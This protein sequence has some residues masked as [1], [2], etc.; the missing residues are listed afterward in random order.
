M[1]SAVDDDWLLALPKVELHVHLEG[2]MSVDTVRLLTDRHG[3]DPTPVWSDGF[4]ERFSFVDFPDFAAQYFY[5]LSLIRTGEDLATVTDDLAVAMAAQNIRYAEV[6]TTAY[7][8]FLDR[9]DRPGMAREEYR[10]GLTEGRRRAAARGVEL[11]WVIDI[12]RDIEV[13]DEEVTI[14]YVTSDL[15]PE[16]LVALGLGGY[17]VGFPAAPYAEQFERARAIGLPAVPHAGETEGAESVRSAI[18]DLGAVRIGHGVRCL[19]DPALVERIAAN[20]VML[21][22]CPTSNLLLGVVDD[23][24]DHALPALIES[25]V[26]VCVNTDDPGWFATDLMTELRLASDRLGVDAAR[27]VAM[28]ADALDASFASADLTTRLRGELTTLG[29]PEA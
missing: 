3:V 25:G 1:T 15:A 26:R 18:D 9:D 16:G 14:D 23:L 27:H 13:P 7:T 11:G 29:A 20:G 4:P 22:V 28:Q 10:D 19:E 5:G 12:P 6:T 24:A 17:E 8:H 21:E 2:S